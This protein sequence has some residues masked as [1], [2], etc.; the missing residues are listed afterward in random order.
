MW[1]GKVVA[2]VM[3]VENVNLLGPYY[4]VYY[5]MQDERRTIQYSMEKMMT[6]TLGIQ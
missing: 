4:D 5:F 1:N 2:V 6:I 3:E